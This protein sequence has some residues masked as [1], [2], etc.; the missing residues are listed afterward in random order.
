MT[1]D[2]TR[3]LRFTGVLLVS[4]FTSMSALSQA[5]SALCQLTLDPEV[6]KLTLHWDS[7]NM[8]G[9]RKESFTES[10]FVQSGQGSSCLIKSQRNSGV[11]AERPCTWNA[12]MSCDLQLGKEPVTHSFT[13]G[14]SY[15]RGK[16][17]WSGNDKLAVKIKR[18][19][20]TT[21]ETRDVAVVKFNGTWSVGPNRG[22]SEST[23]YFDREWG[24]MLK[25]EGAHD[26]NKWG[27]TVTL[28]ERKP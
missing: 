5:G 27:D 7:Y 8:F 10:G 28:V 17:Q 11:V 25:A 14:Q 19:D 1:L 9:N 22:D 6:A 23:I 18:G 26:A 20:A 2:L 3:V 13:S 21:T 12:R 16:L 4:A 24:I 15:Q